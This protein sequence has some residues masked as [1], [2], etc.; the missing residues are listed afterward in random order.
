MRLFAVI[1][2]LG[3]FLVA[4]ATPLPYESGTGLWVFEA[5]NPHALTG[6]E[7]EEAAD[8]LLLVTA[9]NYS[10]P[11][12]GTGSEAPQTTI[13]GVMSAGMV[14]YNGMATASATLPYTPTVRTCVNFSWLVVENTH[15]PVEEH[16]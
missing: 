16:E 14:L 7:I 5:G 11:C 4:A 1:A 10:Q 8:R 12:P 13:P 9:H 6:I 15:P 3:L 2:V